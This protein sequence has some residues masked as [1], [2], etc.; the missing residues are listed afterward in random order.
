MGLGSGLGWAISWFTIRRSYALPLA[1]LADVGERLAD[2]DSVALTNSLSALAQGD[3]T[4]RFQVTAEPAPVSSVPEVDRIV[5][6]FN[7]LVRNLGEASRQFNSVTDE[8]CN[9]LLYVG[10]D[11][12]TEGRT[13][14]EAMGRYVGTRGSVAILTGSFKAPGLEIRRLGFLSLLHEKYPGLKIVEQAETHEIPETAEKLTADLLRKYPDLSGLYMTEGASL[15]GAV[16]AMLSAGA[17][18]RVRL[19]THDTMDETMQAM[20]QGLVAATASQDP[21]AQGHDPAVHLFNHIVTGWRPPQP[22]LLCDIGLVTPENADHFWQAGRGLVLSEAATAKLAKPMK[23]A[24]RPVRLAML[25][26]AAGGSPFWASH[27]HLGATRAHDDLRGFNG[28]VEWVLPPDQNIETWGDIID[29]LVQKGFDG[30]CMPVFDTALIATINRVVAAGTPVATFN[31]ESTSLRGLMVHLVERA[32]VLLEVSDQ[33]SGSAQ[34]SGEATRQISQNISQMALAA[35]SEATAMT[36][37]N[38]SIERI[39]D[40]VEAIATGAREQ[41]AAAESLAAAATRISDAVQI[42]QASSEAVA[43][44]TFESV[45]TAERGS[46]SLRRT[47]QQMESIEKA[48]ESSATTIQ[49][50]N[51]LAQQIGEIVS[52]IE[53]I[54]AQTNLLALNAAIE[55]ARAGEQGK[56]FAVVASEVRKLAEK[57]AGATKE[58]SSIISTV[59]GSARQAAHAMDAAM[60]K[61]H[62]GSS[63]ARHSGDALNELLA[64]AKLTHRQTGEM[65]TANKSMTQVMGELNSAIE[66]VSGV[67]GDNVSR[68]ETAAASIR[69]TLDSVQSVAAISE[70]NAAAAER[71]SE[72]AGMVN[73]QS[74]EVDQAAAGLTGIARELQGSAARFKLK[75]DDAA[76]TKAASAPTNLAGARDRKRAA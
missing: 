32:D 23:A 38:A 2:G 20:Q 76:D 15:P 18:G 42:A 46:E 17:R 19:I 33:L 34:S 3:L 75:R 5:G 44:A 39:A 36:R 57:S 47:L 21:I 53:D 69:E 6:V 73:A 49:G 70:E 29:G 22:R 27:V 60:Q 54:A 12:Y 71:V 59:Q 64:S 37:A 40:S 62:E 4:A 26:P 16:R 14:G 55:A 35:T 56:G 65:V 74:E 72:S 28:S 1:R 67:I 48:V 50:T 45:T 58:I 11:G 24:T 31:G 43:S 8:P 13:C 68:S 52:T 7:T 41:G 30:I 63:L 66:V 51:A 9:R 61:V 25:T 10:A